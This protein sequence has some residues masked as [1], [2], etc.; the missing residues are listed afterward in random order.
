MPT[1]SDVTAGQSPSSQCFKSVIVD[2][3]INERQRRQMTG[4]CQLER[5]KDYKTHFKQKLVKTIGTRWEIL[6]IHAWHMQ[7][8]LFLKAKD[9]VFSVNV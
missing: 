8:L 7:L 4:V 9:Q 6:R 5:E 1:L 3:H 2:A